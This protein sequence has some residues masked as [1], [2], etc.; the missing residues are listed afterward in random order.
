MSNFMN[1]KFSGKC[2]ETSK[3][4]KKNES[5]FFDSN[6]R[7]AFCSESLRYKKELECNCTSDIIQANEDQFFDNFCQQNNI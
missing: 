6:I 2:F 3:A 1:A 7:K 5:I 4:I